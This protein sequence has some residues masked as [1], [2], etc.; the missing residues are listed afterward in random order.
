MMPVMLVV[1]MYQAASGLVLYWLT[2]NVVGIGQQMIFNRL[3][4]A[5]AM[6]VPAGK[7]SI[8]KK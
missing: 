7:S 2:S 8:K 4:P 5:P 6:P 1:F 3:S